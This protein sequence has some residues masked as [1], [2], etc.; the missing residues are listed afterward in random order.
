MNTPF[1][2][3]GRIEIISPSRAVFNAFKRRDKIEDGNRL[4][5]RDYIPNDNLMWRDTTIKT[6]GTGTRA[7][8]VSIQDA[9]LLKISTS[10]CHKLVVPV[11][12][13]FIH[14]TYSL[15]NPDPLPQIP[16]TDQLRCDAYARISGGGFY[17]PVTSSVVMRM[18]TPIF[19]DNWS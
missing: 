4:V 15:A 13:R 16:S 5:T 7:V 18:Q 10:W 6:I 19:N 12:D 1:A 3:R 14:W 2:A 17:V 8:S 11:L 9:N